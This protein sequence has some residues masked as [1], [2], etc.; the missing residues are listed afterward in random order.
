MNK[1]ITKS[2]NFVKNTYTLNGPTN[3]YSYI[4]AGIGI[5]TLL[6]VVN[7]N[8]ISLLVCGFVVHKM[9]KK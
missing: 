4:G 9:F 3:N 1:I 8:I 2:I 6:L 7:S 5:G